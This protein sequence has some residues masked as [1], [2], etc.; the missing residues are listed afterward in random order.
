MSDFLYNFDPADHFTVGTIG[1]PEQQTIILQAGHGIEFV[2]ILCQREQLLALGE[3]LLTLLDQIVESYHLPLPPPESGQDLSLVGPLVPV[4]SVSQI[5]AG[6]NEAEDNIIIVIQIAILNGETKQIAR[7][8]IGRAQAQA[9]AYHAL[10]LIS[11]RKSTCPVCGE[12]LN[13]QRH[14]CPATNGHDKAF[15]L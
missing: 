10:E 6:Y 14:V 15:I 2:S 9:F 5:G 13:L 3:G 4:G 11:T 1:P 7:F 8:T 12:P